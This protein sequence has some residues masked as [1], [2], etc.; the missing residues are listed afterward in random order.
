MILGMGMTVSAQDS[1]TN[2]KDV[3]VIGNRT[4]KPTA[5]VEETIGRQDILRGLGNSLS[6]SLEKVKGLSS[7]RS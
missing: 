7:I 6:S 2:I 1:L 5:Q 3:V 4:R